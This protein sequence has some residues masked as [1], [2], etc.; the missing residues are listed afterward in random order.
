M[1]PEQELRLLYLYDEEIIKR[2]AVHHV[3]AVQF[4]K[5]LRHNEYETLVE[6]YSFDWV[7]FSVKLWERLWKAPTRSLL[8][9]TVLSYLY[10]C[11]QKLHRRLL[12]INF[13]SSM[14][15]LIEVLNNFDGIFKNMKPNIVCEKISSISQ[16]HA[17]LMMP[18]KNI[19]DRLGETSAKKYI[20]R[21]VLDMGEGGFL[22]LLNAVAACSDLA[23]DFVMESYPDFERYYRLFLHER[24]RTK[25]GEVIVLRKYQEEMAQ[26]AYDGQNTLICAPTGTGKTVVAASI[27]RNHL[28]MGRRNN[29][30][31]KIC[32]FVTNTTFL[33]QQAKVFEK[34]VGHRWKVVF[35]S[36]ITVNTPIIETIESYDVIVITP[37]LIVNLLK[38]CNGNDSL[39]FSL[40]S[41]SLMFFDEAHHAD[42]NH[43][44]T[45]IMNDYHDM[46][47]A[48]KI[49]DGKRLPQIVGLTASLGI[50]NAHNASEAVEHFI[51]VCANLDITVLSYVQENIDELR[52]FSSIAADETKLVASNITTDSVAGGILDLFKKFEGILKRTVRSISLPNEIHRHSSRDMLYRLQNPPSDKCSKVY[53]TWFSQL[54]VEFVPVAELEKDSRFLIMT[55]LQFI[56]ILFR[57]L[58]HY[59][60]FPSHVAKKYFEN[61][62]DIVRHTADQELVDIMQTCPLRTIVGSSED[63]ELY[64]ELLRE[65]CSQFSKE[66]D[67]RVI[68]FV[69]TRN[70]A[71]QLAEELNKD[72]NLQILDVKSNF[73]TSI[74]A[75]GEIGGQSLNQQRDILSQFA[76]G[77]IKILCSTSIAE[78]GI[79][80]QKCNLVIKYDYVTNEI[81]HIQ[82]RG[83]SR[84][85]N[86]RCILITCDEKLQAREEKNIIRERIMHSALEFIAQK[87]PNW[88]REEVMKRVQQNTSDRVRKKLLSDAKKTA[89]T[90]MRYT[91]LCKKC[92]SVICDSDDIVVPST[93]SQYFCICK[94]IWSRSI[95]RP[96]PKHMVEREAAYELKG[97]GSISCIKCNH[98][99]GRVVR[100]NNLTLPLIAASAFVLVSEN[101]GRFKKKQWK[102]IVEN[103]FNPRSIELYDY[104]IVTAGAN[105]PNPIFDGFCV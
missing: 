94:E 80:I 92:D 69:Q 48:G 74:N 19:I 50:G 51:K 37:Q 20:L 46:K 17:N 100:Y 7:V 39:P 104:A 25:R 105:I 55:C 41:F 90:S 86:S 66:K 62:F 6:Q 79:D 57:T 9:D 84:A 71:G 22:D 18:V 21:T 32:F 49:L 73:I 33:E 1:S 13:T 63:N 85:T 23:H 97:I 95:Q 35:L 30:Y 31:T 96:F 65:L 28:V 29:V 83:R 59:I 77:D 4:A 75:S 14:R 78:E 47:H 72:A 5:L 44:Y 99:W 45:A 87:P 54:L 103:L 10:T 24:E 76:M 11:D 38:T 56:E 26:A 64:N 101:G 81:A 88:F 98:R 42:G 27:A 8:F 82:R 3:E 68:I 70:F 93:C 53:Q 52:A 67:G 40:S 89:P 2:I 15:D 36:G 12:C 61:E 60:H 43:P 58:E 91:L 34:F 102:Q 16:R